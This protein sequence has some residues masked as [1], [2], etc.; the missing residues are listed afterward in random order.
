MV[1]RTRSVNL[2]ITDAS[3]A[4]VTS[5]SAIQR[6]QMVSWIACP[7]M[8]SASNCE[9]I[10]CVKSGPKWDGSR[11]D[12]GFS[13]TDRFDHEVI[14]ALWRFAGILANWEDDYRHCQAGRFIQNRSACRN[15]ICAL[16]CFCLMSLGGSCPVAQ[17]PFPIAGA[18]DE[19]SGRD[20]QAP[21]P[22]SSNGA[23]VFKAQ[24]GFGRPLALRK[25]VAHF[26]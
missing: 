11:T 5:K 2:D 21:V 15:L 14:V 25:T 19:P 6:S 20:C 7:P 16:S 1:T 3:G 4:A 24:S 23:D 22:T 18:N 9:E 13:A 10:P 12:L 8:L 17:K 26:G